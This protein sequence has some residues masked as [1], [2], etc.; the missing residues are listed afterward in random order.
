[1]DY[2][3][4]VAPAMRTYKTYVTNQS[5]PA[6]LNLLL[7]GQYLKMAKASNIPFW[8]LI[9]TLHGIVSAGA[10]VSSSRASSLTFRT[11]GF[12]A[13]RSSSGRYPDTST[14]SCS[15]TW[16]ATIRSRTSCLTRPS[17][18]QSRTAKL[19]QS[20][21]YLRSRRHQLRPYPR[22]R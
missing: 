13:Q 14:T 21:T 16:M 2:L 9:T 4:I 6:M 15:T 17:N 8:T 12:S 1:M 22:T 18:T 7:V 5:L 10:T 19:P 11:S 3:H 20:S